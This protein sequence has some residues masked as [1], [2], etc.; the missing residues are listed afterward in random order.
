M[1]EVACR[2]CEVPGNRCDDFEDGREQGKTGSVIKRHGADK[3]GNVGVAIMY[4]V[5]EYNSQKDGEKLI[6]SETVFHEAL[7]KKAEYSHVYQDDVPVYDIEKIDNNYTIRNS[8][9][10]QDNGFSE[11]FFDFDHY[12]E[13]DCR[14]I[15]LSLIKQF[16]VLEIEELT[17]YSI[18]IAKIV[19]SRL[20]MQ[21]YVTDPRIRLFIDDPAHIQIVAELPGCPDSMVITKEFLIGIY[22]GDVRKNHSVPLFS[23]LFFLQGLAD[24][25]DLSNVKYCQIEFDKIIGIGAILDT[26]NKME[27]LLA[28][29]GIQ[30]FL[31]ENCSRYNDEML[32]RY[33][34]LKKRPAD[35]DESNTCVCSDFIKLYVI[36]TFQ[37]IQIP[38]KETVIDDG[39]NR[40][41]EEYYEAVFGNDKV[42]GVLIRGTDYKVAEV[43]PSNKQASAGYLI[44]K[45]RKWVEEF[46]FDRI[47]LATEDQDALDT[48]IREFGKDKVRA[49]AQE[50]F[51]VS[52]FKDVHLIKDLEKEKRAGLAYEAALEDI[53]V[54]YFYALKLL[55]K[56]NSFIASGSCSGTKMVLGFNNG[57]FEHQYIYNPLTEKNG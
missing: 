1:A 4:K 25:K 13:N 17:E 40:E 50:R 57:K 22:R 19:A 18:V 48:M 20:N 7:N 38:L 45:I 43:G 26:F 5:L 41:M 49:I 12:D 11:I 31:K 44:P 30:C 46:G 15:N 56:C 36:P 52:E 27:T 24:G 55:A 9:G 33:F 28:G 16:K 29:F 54:N 32:S 8:K 37:M 14:T 47:F 21:V 35:A 51:S 6:H 42:L 53:T 39:F 3:Y 23:E 34:V 10:A 2:G